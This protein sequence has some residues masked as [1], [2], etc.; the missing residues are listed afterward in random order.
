[1]DDNSLPGW[2]WA[3][4][5]ERERFNNEVHAM[6]WT[7]KATSGGDFESPPEGTHNAVCV[8]LIDKG[9]HRREFNG[10]AKMRRELMISWEIDEQRN[11]GK[12]FRVGSTYTL[13]FNEKAKLRQ[14]L[15][16]WRGKKMGDG[17]DFD[18]AAILGKPCMLTLAKNDRGYVNVVGVAGL[19]KGMAPIAPEDGV[20]CFN[21]DSPDNAEF[22]KLSEKM[23]EYIAE[24]PEYE[25]WRK[26]SS[27]PAAAAAPEF[28]DDIPFSNVAA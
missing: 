22:E 9:T 21:L 25:R 15:E 18:L 10:E 1:M 26:R 13:S 8:G 17:E 5:S 7:M 11:D 4:E 14:H 3:Q 12:R 20:I 6:S 27:A 19:P 16:A 2:E 28:D 24:S 23:Q